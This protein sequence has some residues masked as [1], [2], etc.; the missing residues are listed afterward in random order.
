MQVTA[1]KRARE[2]LN[3]SRTA[4]Y[5]RR[6]AKP[7]SRAVRD[8]ELTQQIADVH[9]RSRGTYGAPRVHAVLKRAGAG[10]GRR[11]V[12]RLMRAGA[13]RANTADDGIRRRSPVHE[14]S[15]GP[16]SSSGTCGREIVAS[17]NRLIPQAKL[18]ETGSPVGLASPTRQPSDPP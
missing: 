5:A 10:C 16:A 1:F 4:F 18:S 13:C 8:T 7:G 3:V 17:S 15:C 6:A 9:T 14:P 2:L 12:A 11:R